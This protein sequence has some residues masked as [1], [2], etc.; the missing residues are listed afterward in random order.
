MHRRIRMR[1]TGSKKGA[2]V[3]SAV[4]CLCFG[5]QGA[6]AEQWDALVDDA[7]GFC[8]PRTMPLPVYRWPQLTGKKMLVLRR[9]HQ[10]M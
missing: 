4:S 9:W 1:R 7:G 2:A 8:S 10:Y 5:L 6:C 3:L